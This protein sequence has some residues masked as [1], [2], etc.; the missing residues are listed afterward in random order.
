MT[1]RAELLSTARRDG[2]RRAAFRS[3]PVE[4]RAR[5]K[6]ELE[7]EYR[8]KRY[9][10][11]SPSSPSTESRT[12]PNPLAVNNLQACLPRIHLLLAVALL[13][14]ASATASLEDA[15]TALRE[16]RYD[17]AI[18]AFEDE[19]VATPTPRLYKG[20]IEA[21]R[22]TGRYDEALARVDAFLEKEPASVELENTRGEI[23]YERGRIDEARGAFEKSNSGGARDHLVAELNLA[24]LAYESGDVAEAMRGFDRFIDVYNQNSR[25]RAEELTAVAVACWYLGATN[26][27]LYRDALKAFDEAKALDPASHEPTLLVGALFLEKYNSPD[28]SSSF[29]Q[30][31]GVNAQHP[32]ALLGLAKVKAFDG[33]P[34]ALTLTEQ[35]LEINPSYVAARAFLAEQRLGLEEFDDAR[36]EARKALEVNPVSPEALPILAAAE[37]LSGDGAA[38]SEVERR[39][40]EQNPRDADFYNKLADI[41]VQNRLY[42]RAVA[43]SSKAVELNDRSWSAYGALG[44]NQLRLGDIE[45][46]RANLERSFEGDPYNVWNK[47]T[48]DLLDT[49]PDYVTTETERFELFI[50][51]SE[52]ELLAVYFGKVAEQAYEALAAQYDYRPPTPIRIEVF[53]SHGDFS[54]RTLGLPGLGALGVCFGPVIAVD[55][56]SARPKGQF[57]WASTLWHELAHT[58]T[59]GVTDHKVPRWFSEGLS[60]LEERRALPGWGDDVNLGF[61][62]A[63]Q[64]EKLLPIAELN[65]G[66]MRPTYPQ[67]IGISYYQASLV[68]ELI[69]RD[70]GF[71]AI[72][73][74]LAGYRDGFATPEVFQQ[75]LGLSLDA[76]DERFDAYLAERFDTVAATLRLPPEGEAPPTEVE[77]LASRAE[78]D[79]FDFI[80]H[81]ETG[82]R[83]LA[84]GD[85]DT[86]EK[87]LER[88]KELFPG[89]AEEGSP[90]LVLAQMHEDAGRSKRAA[91]ELQTFVDLNEN[92]YDAHVK[93]SQL[94]QELAET[95][96]AAEMLERALYIYPFELIVHE[97]L[98]ALLRESGRYSD[99]VVERRALLALTT[100]RAQAL[101]DL[102]L[103]YHEAG[104][105]VSARRELLRA[106]EL[107][108][109]F[110]DGLR[111]LLTLKAAEGDA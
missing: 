99:V 83:A 108:P 73:D 30:V 46:G 9:A 106:L 91:T 52:S 61:L 74:M 95:E 4:R 62:A 107:A 110:K 48:L 58:F 7:R 51:G 40:L 90:Y 35:A 68:S 29:E 19:S 98:A 93:L 42:E 17:D 33:S 5:P 102:A 69:E 23:L 77:D 34:E 36:D 8:D 45:D 41:A 24:I 49:F 56:P 38:F 47:N 109:A 53:P 10:L 50:E 11:E 79:E 76:F 86:A 65:N 31:L 3:E 94:Y 89:Y 44:V 88:A 15:E 26:P 39:A 54:V 80:A 97:D 87:H 84:D 66:F 43:F 60:V 101:Y 75:A 25:L 63:Y 2:D 71:Q 57:N 1:H 18:A 85:T 37:L 100:D 21:L 72:R 55:S 82:R 105:N 92:H 103:A 12:S 13:F 22:L 28:A 111:L 64:R 78:R 14:T 104:D 6:A 81:L 67:Q 16:G 59:L 96:K 20:W 27:Q 32:E 70:Y